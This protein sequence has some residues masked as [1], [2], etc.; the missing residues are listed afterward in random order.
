MVMTTNNKIH[1]KKVIEKI[2]EMMEG[3]TPP[4]DLI[5]VQYHFNVLSSTFTEMNNSEIK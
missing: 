3:I 2:I 5:V 1:K 4:I